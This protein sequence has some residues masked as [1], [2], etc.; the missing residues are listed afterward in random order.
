MQR[1]CE[2]SPRKKVITHRWYESKSFEH[3]KCLEM[4]FWINERKEF[5]NIKCYVLPSV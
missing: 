4:F 3:E 5:E 1:S 2:I